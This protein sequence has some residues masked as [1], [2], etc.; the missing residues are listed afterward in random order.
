M[1]YLYDTYEHF[2]GIERVKNSSIIHRLED[3]EKIF[4]SPEELKTLEDQIDIDYFI[5]ND[6]RNYSLNL[7]K[8]VDAILTNRGLI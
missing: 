5:S 6:T 4:T 7:G 3:L 8:A 1:K 2:R